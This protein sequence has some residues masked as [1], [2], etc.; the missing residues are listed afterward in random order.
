[1]KGVEMEVNSKLTAGFVPSED[2]TVI[3]NMREAGAVCLG[4]VATHEFAWGC[5]SPPA[6]NPW[7]AP[8][9]REA[10]A[11]VRGQLWPAVRVLHQSGQTAPV[12][13]ETLPH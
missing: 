10:R 5:V 9:G 6:T 11:V 13:C 1:M 2:A 8:S 3:K 12:Q 4:K 7:N